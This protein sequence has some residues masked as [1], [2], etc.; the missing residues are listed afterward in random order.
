MGM[1]DSHI[2]LM[3][4]DDMACNPRYLHKYKHL[5]VY[6]LHTHTHTH[7]HTHSAAMYDCEGFRV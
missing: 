5:Y 7:T 6:V 3:L 2:I 4:A 1:P